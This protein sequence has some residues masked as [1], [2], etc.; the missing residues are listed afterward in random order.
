MAQRLIHNGEIVITNPER[1]RVLAGADGAKQQ[2]TPNSTRFNR[3]GTP[4]WLSFAAAVRIVHAERNGLDCGDS[5]TVT[6]RV[7]LIIAS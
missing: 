3:P 4:N 5:S 1:F 2:K 6:L 7:R